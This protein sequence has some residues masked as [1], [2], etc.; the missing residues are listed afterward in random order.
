MKRNLALFLLL[1]LA[2]AGC[3]KSDDDTT[4]NPSKDGIVGKWYSSRTNIAP[5]LANYCDSIYA[6]FKSDFTYTVKSYKTGS[7]TTMTGT[8]SQVKPTTGTIWA[9]TVNQ[10]TPT[11]LTST[12]IF[13]IDATTTPFSMKYEVIQ[14]QPVI[15]GFSAPTVEGGFGSTKYNNVALA[16]Y[17]QKYKRTDL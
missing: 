6:E 11:T 4:Y 3:K 17:I 9:I 2:I 16:Y 14:V 1:A 12:G 15:T 8:F 13:E 7:L 10:S 5:G